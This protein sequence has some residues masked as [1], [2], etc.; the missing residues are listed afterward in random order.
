MSPSERNPELGRSRP[1]A[2]AIYPASVYSLPDLDELDRISDGV[3]PGYSYAR[4]KHPNAAELAARMA[5]AHQAQWGVVAASG[6]GAIAATL[7]S[8]LR[9]G[10]RVVASDQL[11]GGTAQLL[12]SLLPR[13]GV[14]TSLVD[15]C[16]VASVREA[17]SKPVKLVFIETM[18]NPLLRVPDV[19]QLAELAHS[20]QALLLVDNTF[21]SPVLFRP[22]AHGADLVVESM[23]KIIGGHSDM[24]LGGVFG[25]DPAI[26]AEVARSAS[27]WGMPA[28]PFDCWLAVRSLATLDLRIRA[29]AANASQ[30][31]TWLDQRS[32]VAK[33]VYPGLASHPDHSRAM[34]LFSGPP[35]NMVAF[36]LPGGRSAVN[37][38]MR[39]GPG[40][41]FCPSLGGT[42]TS[43]S[44]PFGTSH[45]FLNPIEKE[46]LG[47]TAGLIRLSVGIES[48]EQIIEDLAAKLR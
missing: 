40:I 23:T 10:D 16:S 47:V 15:T 41:P 6:M 22:L 43:C 21:A 37:Q 18:S 4:D 3:E 7:L 27:L 26:G 29:A 11:Y 14:E 32:G 45:R 44:Y 42:E 2:P 46:R 30:L 20:R 19:G 35:G 48:V 25:N 33:V 9:C 8:V 28:S 34:E 1:A 17:L 13:F 38:F 24:T 36:E 31:A 39:Q 12:R 5:E